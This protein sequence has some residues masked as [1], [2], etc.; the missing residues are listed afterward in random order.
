MAD[1]QKRIRNGTHMRFKDVTWMSNKTNITPTWWHNMQQ[2]HAAPVGRALEMQ[3]RFGV[4]VCFSCIWICRCWLVLIISICFWSAGVFWFGI[5]KISGDFASLYIILLL[6]HV[7]TETLSM[8]GMLILVHKLAILP[9]QL[10]CQSW[11][12]QVPLIARVYSHRW[13]WWCKCQS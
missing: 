11:H 4:V 1:D 3:P 13:R 12:R 9:Q 5:G 2:H 6:T 7:S 8:D 10:K